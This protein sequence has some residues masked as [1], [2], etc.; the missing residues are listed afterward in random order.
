MIKACVGKRGVFSQLSRLCHIYM[1]C[2]IKLV[3]GR[4]CEIHRR[5]MEWVERVVRSRE[6]DR[7]VRLSC[8]LCSSPVS[9]L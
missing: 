3:G 2:L 8:K 4:L 6:S 1:H 9:I 7:I 5:W